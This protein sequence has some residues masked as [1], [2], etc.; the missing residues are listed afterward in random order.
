M[1]R[2]EFHSLRNL[3]TN[4]KLKLTN[5]DIKSVQGDTGRIWSQRSTSYIIDEDRRLNAEKM[6]RIF[7]RNDSY[8]EKET[9]DKK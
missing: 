8:K 9:E 4:Y 6:D 7:Y 3:S 1:Q 2:V 5:G